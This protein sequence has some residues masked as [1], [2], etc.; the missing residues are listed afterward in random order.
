MDPVTW[1]YAI[2][3]TVA[4]GLTV[5]LAMTLSRH[6]K[7]FLAELFP[8]NT[9]VAKAINSLLVTG[10]FMVNLG[11]SF[12]ISKTEPAATVYLATEGLIRKLGV[13]LLSLGVMHF[14][15][16]AVFWRIRRNLT[17]ETA[18]PVPA[19]AMVMPPPP[20]APGEGDFTWASA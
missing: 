1:P 13:L 6:G 8:E 4:I 20:P 2:Y 11:Y 9:A 18:I 16:M 7:V 19:N 14:V 15:N 3:A 5:L 12:M 17:N 10:F